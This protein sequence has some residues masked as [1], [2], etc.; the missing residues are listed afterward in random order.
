MALELPACL[1]HQEAPASREPVVL[2]EDLE[3]P[4]DLD[5]L[6]LQARRAHPVLLDC[7]E[8][9]DRLDFLV[10]LACQD[11]LG[12]VDSRVPQD[13]EGSQAPPVALDSQDQLDLVAQ[14]VRVYLLV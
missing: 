9:P 1:D 13:R 11:Y 7:L 8:A 12:R 6:V 5:P 14:A 3:V 10:P 4:V 2:V